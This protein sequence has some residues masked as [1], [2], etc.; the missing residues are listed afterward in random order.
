MRHA[1]LSKLV[2]LFACFIGS[3]VSNGQQLVTPPGAAPGRPIEG[4]T[5]GHYES[6]LPA[7]SDLTPSV[8]V[9][10]DPYG[11]RC[12]A[13]AAYSRAKTDFGKI[14]GAGPQATASFEHF[15]SAQNHCSQTIRLRVC[16]HG[17]QNCVPMDVPPYGRQQ[18]SLGVAPGMPGFRYQYTEQF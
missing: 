11:K 18:A 6:E 17:S 9:H 5:G 13:V 1:N 10:L 12:V 2:I 16:Y 3:N 14:F 4:S 7:Q 8:R 15:I